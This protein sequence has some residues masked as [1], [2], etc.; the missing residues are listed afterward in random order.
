MNE[1][2][3]AAWLDLREPVDHRSRAAEV[4]APLRRWWT[5]RGASSVLDLGCGTGSNLRYLA[6]R[7]PGPQRWT[8]VDHDAVLL[9][10]VSAPR[11][12][13]TVRALCGDLG[14][15]GL[16]EVKGS[17]LVTASALLDLASMA[18]LERLVDECASARSA[19]LFAL[20]YDGTTDWPGG[21]DSVGSEVRD[22]VNEHQR[23]DKGLGPA[24]GPQA[25]TAA[26]AL[27]Q[28][29]GYST[30]LFPS[31]WT[32]GPAD[33]ALSRE[34]IRGWIAAAAESRANDASRMRAWGERMRDAASDSGFKLVVG[35]LDLL[36]LPPATAS[37]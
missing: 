34:L 20:T 26:E 30:R 17:D 5:A 14:D 15:V 7:L 3:A 21:S 37:R 1:T 13:V 31:P 28:S 25:A 19:A 35:H 33:A 36:A 29:R 23:R 16:A 10:R 18:W 11:E 2:F 24:L 6:P 27:F 32:L 12:D 4:L 8:S 22:A 9:E